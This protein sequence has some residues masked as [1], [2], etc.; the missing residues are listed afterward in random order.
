MTLK[1]G[2]R[3]GPFEIVSPLGAGGMGEVYRGRDMRLG[4]DV[5]IKVLPKRFISSPDFRQRFEREARAISSLQHPH[6]CVLY[7]VGHDDAA[8]EY[9]VMEYLEGESVAERL[10]RGKLPL[11]DLLKIGM[12]VAGALDKAHR[13][14]VVHR[15]LKPANIMLT[16]GGAK[17]MDFGLAKPV[18]SSVAGGA[19]SAPL[20]SA[21]VTAT[22][23]A[24]PGS[25]ITQ[26]GVMVGTIHYM[27][28]EQ[29]EGKEAD[30]RSDIFAFGA[31]LYEMATGVRAFEGKNQ[32]SVAAA[33]LEKDPE[34]IS[35]VQPL[36][37]AALD[38]LVAQCLAKN[39]D[40]R[41]Q[42]AHDVG[43][44]LK[45]ISEAPVAAVSDRRGVDQRSTL[46]R[47][48]PWTL[49]AAGVLAAIILGSL[50]LRLL[51]A[52]SSSVHSYILPPDKATFDPYARATISPDG[53]RI[54]FGA[55]GSAGRPT[56]WVQPL[57]S[58]TAQPLA[59]TEGATYPFW[60]A[61][62]RYLGYFADGK[63]NKIDASGGPPQ[64][65]CDAPTGRG[66]TWSQDGII[67]FASDQA[68]PLMRVEATGGTPE[69]ATV[70]EQGGGTPLYRSPWFLPD[71]HHFLYFSTSVS[72]VDRGIYAGAL[73]S[74]EQ[75]L[76]GH[77]D[78]NTIYAPPGYLLFVR[79][80]TLMA[81][82]FNTSKLAVEGEALPVAERVGIA[83][84]TV[85]ASGVL[86]YQEGGRNATVSQL[87]WFD[88][89]GKQIGLALPET[90]QYFDPMLSPDGSKLAVTIYDS[91]ATSDVWVIDL[92]RQTKTRITF[93]PRS[94]A[95]PVWWPDGR[96]IV[97]GS[98]RD[99]GYA[100]YRR[101]ADGT[102]ADE[103][104]LETPGSEIEP[105]SVSPDGRYIAYQ[106]FGS[107][108]NANDVW[109]LPMFGDRKPFPVVNTP[110]NEVDPAISPDGKWIAYLSNDSGQYEVYIK[111]FPSGEG[112][113]QVSTTGSRG[114]PVWRRDGKELYFLSLGGKLTAVEVQEKGAGLELGTPQE[115]FQANTF[116]ITG[117]PFAASA[118]GKRFLINGTTAQAA[119]Q[120]LTLVTNW[121]ADLKK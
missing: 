11:A 32:L 59:G 25:P 115:L 15:D 20:L 50:W 38:R 76:V 34:P 75:V 109:A 98:N 103:K 105:Y 99:G 24:G 87:I 3:L 30:A 107:K 112:K 96:S 22:G 14:G 114:L 97:F 27:S 18:A 17:L 80:G 39:P 31:T 68:G 102:G 26:A 83:R 43:V 8:G 33:I 110:F 119:S 58:G 95:F 108:A 19:G 104:I 118:D 86:L 66:G 35:K 121:T 113:W 106:F 111:P 56:L 53:R 45:W 1:A 116:S 37:P 120:P 117:T 72:G 88:R 42:S 4:R 49:A 28:P 2:T 78:S 57:N 41:L 101:A 6:I 63:L 79:N 55:T 44:E 54:A 51:L 64:A 5:A 7:D 13:Q 48:L 36:A 100:I 90:A 47:A 52:P 70:T 74:K 77:I 93:G 61:D 12:Q 62:S 65:L 67:V 81:Q 10:K 29:I 21:A 73:G 16:K 91:P 92:A 84:F 23:G 69:A 60:S 94:N 85:S 40:E 89:A 46:Q 71:G 82:R 9:L